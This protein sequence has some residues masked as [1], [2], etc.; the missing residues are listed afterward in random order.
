MY[1]KVECVRESKDL[2]TAGDESIS[3]ENRWMGL[4]NMARQSLEQ[5]FDL[6]EKIIV[7]GCH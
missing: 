2:L 5:A 3:T 4:V 6:L 1:K 7:S